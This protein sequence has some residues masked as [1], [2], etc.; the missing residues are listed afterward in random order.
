MRRLLLN[1]LEMKSAFG[2]ISGDNTNSIHSQWH[3]VAMNS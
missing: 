1:P 2:R 3:E